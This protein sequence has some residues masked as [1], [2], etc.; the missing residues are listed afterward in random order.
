MQQPRLPLDEIE[1]G[2]LPPADPAPEPKLYRLLGE[3]RDDSPAVL[4]T[5]IVGWTFEDRI[6]WITGSNGSIT[7]YNFDFYL[8]LRI[9]PM[10]VA[11]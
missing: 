11:P 4:Q 3:S 10:E 2:D 5:D 9:M 7:G 1:Y 6:W 8:M